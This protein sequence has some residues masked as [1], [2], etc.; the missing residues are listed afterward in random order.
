M[1]VSDFILFTRKKNLIVISIIYCYFKNI[2][3]FL[4]RNETTKNNILYQ[5][6]NFQTY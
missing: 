6:E 5:Q 4:F 3:Y 1:M 2:I